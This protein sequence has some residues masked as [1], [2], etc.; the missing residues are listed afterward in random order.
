MNKEQNDIKVEQQKLCEDCSCEID[1]ET[2][3]ANSGLC[4]TCLRSLKM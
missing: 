1:K 4:D 2:Y 3:K